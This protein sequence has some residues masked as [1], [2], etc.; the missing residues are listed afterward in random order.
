[1]EAK[2]PQL[3]RED[4]RAMMLFVSEEAAMHLVLA[5]LSREKVR[6]LMQGLLDDWVRL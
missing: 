2:S 1:M 4:K 6:T 5:R 3:D